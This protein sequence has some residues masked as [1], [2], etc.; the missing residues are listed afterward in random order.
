MNDGVMELEMCCPIRVLFAEIKVLNQSVEQC[1]MQKAKVLNLMALLQLN[2]HQCDSNM[3]DNSSSAL[4]SLLF[5]AD[6]RTH[7]SEDNQ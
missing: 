2:P 6:P 4:C 5:S 1:P 7:W 3:Q